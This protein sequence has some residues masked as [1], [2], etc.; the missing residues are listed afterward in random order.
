MGQCDR[1][2]YTSLFTHSMGRCYAFLLG[3]SLLSSGCAAPSVG[4]SQH[5]SRG[6]APDF[7]LPTTTG[8]T[9]ELSELRGR[10]VLLAFFASWSGPSKRLLRALGALSSALGSQG[11]VVL[12]IAVDGP[13]TVSEVGAMVTAHGAER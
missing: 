1:R 3:I 8:R 7:A 9:I 5:A 11:L 13:D 2:S 6:R 4:S 12:A 10:V